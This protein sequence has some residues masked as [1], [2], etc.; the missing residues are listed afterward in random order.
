MGELM[1]HLPD[2]LRRSPETTAFQ[3]AWQPEIDAL[4]AARNDLLAQLDP[5]TATWG[6]ELWERALFGSSQSGAL[7]ARRARVLGMVA[8]RGTVTPELVQ[9]LAEQASGGAVELTEQFGSHHIE[10][11]FSGTF[12]IPP[13]MDALDQTLRELLPAHLSWSYAYVFRQWGALRTWRWGQLQSAT[14]LDLKQEE[15]KA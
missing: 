5:D 8:G 15:I 7:P 4:W 10:L 9:R 6:L 11:Y 2:N 12:G 14:Y 13:N 3:L 1:D